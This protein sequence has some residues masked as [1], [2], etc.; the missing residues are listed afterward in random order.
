LERNIGGIEHIASSRQ[1][2]ERKKPWNLEMGRLE[3]EKQR[4]KMGLR[5]SGVPLERHLNGL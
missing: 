2:K 3:I 5:S 4:T 1:I